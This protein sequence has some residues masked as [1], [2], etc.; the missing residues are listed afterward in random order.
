MQ[1]FYYNPIYQLIKTPKLMI[2]PIL[3]YG[4]SI[5]KKR[6]LPISVKTK[7]NKTKNKNEK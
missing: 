1:Q 6:A 4:N 3:S 7:N 2:L 5:L